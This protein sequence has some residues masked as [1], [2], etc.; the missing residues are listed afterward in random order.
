MSSLLR[1]AQWC[2]LLVALVFTASAQMPSLFLFPTNGLDQVDPSTTITIKAPAPIDPACI[3]HNYPDAEHGSVVAPVPTI[4]LISDHGDVVLGRYTLDDE[5]TLTF[6]PRP[7]APGTRYRCIVSNIALLN[8]GYVPLPTEE[9]RFTTA[10]EVPRILSCS[11]EGADQISCDAEIELR[12]N[13]SVTDDLPEVLRTISIVATDTSTWP[14]P[15]EHG[16]ALSQDGRKLT[17]SPVVRWPAG[18]SLTIA[19]QLSTITGDVLDDRSWTS[20]VRSTGKVNV[21]PKNLDGRAIPE[22]LAAAYRAQEHVA[23]TGTAIDLV[24]IDDHADRW[25]FVRWESPLIEL[26]ADRN[27]HVTI[28]CELYSASIPIEAI[29]EHLDTISVQITVEEGGVVEVYDLGGRRLMTVSDSTEVLL[30]DSLPDVRL[31]AK[32][33][34]TYSFAS[35]I[36]SRSSLHGSPAPSVAIL[37]SAVPQVAWNNGNTPQGPK[38]RPSFRKTKATSERYALRGSIQDEDAQPGFN[39][40]DAVAFTTAKAFESAKPGERTICVEAE[41]CWE[42]IGYTIGATG[43]RVDVASTNNYCVTAELMDPEN[44]VTF[45]VRRRKIQLRLEK[46]LLSS[47]D[48]KDV[49]VGKKPHAESYVRVEVRTRTVNDNVVWT[50]LGEQA[51]DD[52]GIYFGNYALRCGDE[53]RFRVRGSAARSQTWASW[54]PRVNYVVPGKVDETTDEVMYSMVIDRDIANFQGSTC[55]L[56]PNGQQQIRVRGCF[57]QRFGVEAIGLSLRLTKGSNRGEAYFAER[58]LDPLVYRDKLPEEPMGCGSFKSQKEKVYPKVGRCD[59]F[60]IF[61]TI[62]DTTVK[63]LNDNYCT[64]TARSLNY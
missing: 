54:D 2:A 63:F 40:A 6:H 28:P 23:V 7:L 45:H 62:C 50:A 17:F 22:E 53:V 32:A 11:L 5:R 52:N 64:K 48:F 15:I 41:R 13:R 55:D 51:C 25:R 39:V 27:L 16:F 4:L 20:V 38:I 3:T 58:W 59:I 21:I 43:E 8:G 14:Q 19:G 35:W 30:T 10:A 36:A 18:M 33:D 34:T 61:G 60:V 1:V 37:S 47:E 31:I 26:P 57:Y 24:A 56:Q 12:F 49:I 46:V 44:T 9:I 29:L 42:I